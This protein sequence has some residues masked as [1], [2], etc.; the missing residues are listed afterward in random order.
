MV[1]TAVIRLTGLSSSK[2]VAASRITRLAAEFIP[3]LFY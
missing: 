2:R 3:L 1:P